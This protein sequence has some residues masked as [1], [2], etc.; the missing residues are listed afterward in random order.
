MV[1]SG[2]FH[3]GVLRHGNPHMSFVFSNSIFRPQSVSKRCR[4]ALR[5][6]YK[7]FPK[8]YDTINFC[9]ASRGFSC[10]KISLKMK[11]YEIELP[12]Y[13]QVSINKPFP[14]QSLTAFVPNWESLY[15]YFTRIVHR[16]AQD[17]H[18]ARAWT[19]RW[20]HKYFIHSFI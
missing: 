17:F 1:S 6:Q 14:F 18:T 12:I 20:L 2:T 8:H 3:V 7:S 16:W 15:F 10:S 13:V 19:A 5:I 9:N 11:S 4:S